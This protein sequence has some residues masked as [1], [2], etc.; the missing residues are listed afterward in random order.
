VGYTYKYAVRAE[1]S[2]GGELLQKTIAVT[3]AANDRKSVVLDFPSKDT[4][5]PTV[6]RQ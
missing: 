4:V 3:L 5:L 2:R 6:A 1:V